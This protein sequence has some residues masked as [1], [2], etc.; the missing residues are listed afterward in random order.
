MQQALELYIQ[1]KAVTDI[2][3]SQSRVE[4]QEIDANKAAVCLNL[5]AVHLRQ[6]SCLQAI[7]LCTE[8]LE[9]VAPSAKAHL[10]RAKAYLLLHQYQVPA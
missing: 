1:A 9:A 2:I 6:H 4:Q 7:S 10:R 5:A 8:A 3:A